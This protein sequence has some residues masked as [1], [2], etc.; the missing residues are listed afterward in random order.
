MEIRGCITGPRDH[1]FQPGLRSVAG[2]PDDA[3]AQID[4]GRARADARARVRA[5]AAL[6]AAAWRPWRP[7]HQ[8]PLGFWPVWTGFPFFGFFEKSIDVDFLR[9]TSTWLQNENAA[10]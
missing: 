6:V 9:I 1:P 8:D 3:Q 7:P 4:S 5:R 10:N 2:Q